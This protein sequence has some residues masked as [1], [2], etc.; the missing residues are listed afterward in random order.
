[1]AVPEERHL[2]AV[3]GER[4]SSVRNRAQDRKHSKVTFEIVY[5]GVRQAADARALS[6]GDVLSLTDPK[7]GRQE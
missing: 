2:R 4:D 6:A 7:T 5:G 3:S 1:M